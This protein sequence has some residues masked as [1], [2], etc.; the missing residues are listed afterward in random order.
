MECNSCGKNKK[1]SEM[2]TA[3]FGVVCVSCIN[4]KDMFKCYNCDKYHDGDDRVTYDGDSICHS[5]YREDYFRC[6]DC[7]DIYPDRYD[8]GNGRCEDCS[9]GSDNNRFERRGFNASSKKFQ[10]EDDGKII[11]SKR[12]FGVEMECVG[13]ADGLSQEIAREFGLVGDS[14]INPDGRR[15]STVQNNEGL[16]VVTPV[17]KGKKGEEILTK[18]CKVL[19]KHG[20][21][22]NK[23]T[24][25]HVH[26]G[27]S[28][29]LPEELKV[30]NFSE[31]DKIFKHINE[32]GI[33]PVVIPNTLYEELGNN[34]Y[35][36]QT[37]VEKFLS[38]FSE[39]KIYNSKTVTI[40]SSDGEYRAHLSFVNK[41]KDNG[42][43]PVEATP[44]NNA[45]VIF[46]GGKQ[47]NKL[48]T[49]FAFYLT[50][51]DVIFATQPKSRRE[52]NGFCLKLKDAF[53]IYDL[54]NFESVSDIE[55][56]WYKS[57][58]SR[59][60]SSIK[61]E[62]YG[63][64][65]YYHFNLHPL[66]SSGKGETIEMRL[67][68]GTLNHKKILYWVKL[69]QTIF[70][71]VATEKISFDDIRK[72]SDIYLLEDKVDAFFK[73]IKLDKTTEQYFKDRIDRLTLSVKKKKA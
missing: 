16:E 68:S 51:E 31:V 27:S 61:N 65:R 21:Y 63:N 29:F 57:T 64:S 10:S 43:F 6:N 33:V 1:V 67:H 19:Q 32:N 72:A 40:I 37:G 69:H 55:K 52:K 46:V 48:S 25:L 59:K 4:E 11:K 39:S 62:K 3:T 60:L 53:G 38:E 36:S 30:V 5:C 28:D 24:G 9:D 15:D 54:R 45:K 34:G 44:K 26:L 12:T 70:D 73:L 18:T 2:K 47:T 13:R 23:S 50:F 66:F 56:Y 20:N 42:E 17:L 14:S 35:Y 49:L 58:S 41:I 22:T 8:D 71:L 7:E